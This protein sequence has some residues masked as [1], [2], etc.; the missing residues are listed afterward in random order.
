MTNP[1][2]L[3]T[4]DQIIATHLPS[5]SKVTF[6]GELFEK[7]HTITYA[8][9]ENA[10]QKQPIQDITTELQSFFASDNPTHTSV[11]RL[12]SAL[13]NQDFSGVSVDNPEYITLLKVTFL[14][15][16]LIRQIIREVV[17]G[18]NG[19]HLT[20]AATIYLTYGTQFLEKFD[21]M[22]L[23]L[24]SYV[25]HGKAFQYLTQLQNDYE[26]SLPADTTPDPLFAFKKYFEPL[27]KGHGE[28]LY[29]LP[30]LSEDGQLS[31]VTYA[32]F[33]HD[34]LHGS[35]E[36][37]GTIDLMQEMITRLRE[38]AA[39][40]PYAQG[41]V[42]VHQ[43]LIALLTCTQ[44]AVRQEELAQEMDKAFV[45]A[46]QIVTDK[47]YLPVLA[48]PPMEAYL[49]SWK[50]HVEMQYMMGFVDTRHSIMNEDIQHAKDTFLKVLPTLGDFTVITSSTPSMQKCVAVFYDLL[51]GGTT[52]RSLASNIPNR[53]PIRLT[54]GNIIDLDY[55]SFVKKAEMSQVLLKK[56]FGDTP[57]WDAYFADTEEL[58]RKSGVF[59]GLHEVG[60]N[61]FNE[62]DTAKRLTSP[63][64]ANLEEAKSDMCGVVGGLYLYHDQ[65]G[66][67]QKYIAALLSQNVRGLT[68]WQDR[69]D[70]THFHGNVIIIGLLQEAGI[71]TQEK[72]K[73]QFA[74]TS[75]NIQ[76]LQ[77][78][79]REILRDFI[80]IYQDRDP[81]AALA[82]MGPMYDENKAR[83]FAQSVGID[84]RPA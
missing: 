23:K 83:A 81:E 8:L 2:T 59:V 12:K 40:D 3:P 17:L 61:A 20:P 41:L 32:E 51:R 28:F 37:P 48:F 22:Q 80:K 35:P 68:R 62:E 47:N 42:D 16:R 11:E 5:L 44:S 14:R 29:A 73:W 57:T 52:Y 55:T 67:Q 25:M 4:L 75:E 63:I 65:P 31:A 26:K 7:T 79:S 45:Q 38:A 58:I 46:G 15:E 82:F 74:P 78:R 18:E 84:T 60:H 56:V 36:S 54:Y 72:K 69:D 21:A 70:R 43:A 30:V 1:T 77:E 39:D 64:Y 19:L 49:G 76:K 34:E 13:Y 10:L 6:I 53:L 50:M 9:I 71:L 33:F 27:I 66:E 24:L